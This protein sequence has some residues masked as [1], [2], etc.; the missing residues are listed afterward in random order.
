MFQV[1]HSIN[2]LIAQEIMGANYEDM[3]DLILR[4]QSDYV[5]VAEVLADNVFEV[6]D[7]TTSKERPWVFNQDVLFSE[8]DE[9][10][11][12]SLMDGDLLVSKD[13]VYVMTKEF[14]FLIENAIA[15]L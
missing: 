8:S 6:M 7:L 1:F 2:P 10:T 11:I 4:S 15:A 13:Q 9:G 5:K 14:P 12:R 3:T